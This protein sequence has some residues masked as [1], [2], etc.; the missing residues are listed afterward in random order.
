LSFDAQTA[1][2]LGGLKGNQNLSL[3]NASSAPVALSVGSN[4]Q[5][6]TYSGILS[7]AGSLTKAGNGIF[8]LTRANTYTGPTT[9]SAGTLAYGANNVIATGP[10]T[11][12][13]SSAILSLGGYSDAVGTVTVDGGGRI[14]GSGTLTSTGSFEMKSGSVSAI[15]AGSGIALNKT[16]SDMVTLSKANTY[17]G[18]TTV[19]AG[20]LMVNGSLAAGSAVTVSGGTLGGSGT[21]NGPLTVQSLGVLSP[22]N[23]I[24]TLTVNN[25]LTLDGQTLMEIN[26]IGSAL[27][28]DRIVGVSTLTCGGVLTVT[29]TGDAFGFGDTWY[30][31]DA[32]AFD[33]SF[34]GYN[35]P[36]LGSSLSW[37]TSK[38]VVDGTLGVV[39]E[40]CSPVLLVAAGLGLLTYRWRRRRS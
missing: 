3:A 11:V 1:A 38:L 13:G 22:G 39:S 14:T 7:G 8:T 9:I 24:G 28:S 26:K 32:A 31:F 35:L 4:G 37:D 40:P 18:T 21:I 23:S 20:T 17:T 15:L 16:T 10:V 2:T 36:A 34:T 12:N 27:A 25:S 6:T 19:S 33:G 29:G 5:S 30:L